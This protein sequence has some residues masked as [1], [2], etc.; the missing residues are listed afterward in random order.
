MKKLIFG[1]LALAATLAGP[2]IA[3]DMPV[4]ALPPVPVFSWTGCYAGLNVGPTSA[5]F[6]ESSVTSVGIPPVV[7]TNSTFADFDF[8]ARGASGGGQIGCNW[9]NGVVVWGVETDIQATQL[10][11]RKLFDN[12]IFEF[13]QAGA[14]DTDVRSA[15]RY[16]GTVRGRVGWTPTA[17][18]L[19]YL[20]GGFAYAQ[21]ASSLLF[22]T[23]AGV[24]TAFVAFDKQTHFGYTIGLGAEAKVAENF[25]VKLE[26]LYADVGRKTYNFLNV[27]GIN[28]RWDERV[29]FHTVRLGLNYNFNWYAPPVV[30]KY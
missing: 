2:A 21:V 6:R 8:P 30:A 13:P 20:T 10:E 14:F 1:S 27:A 4:K 29:D 16:F 23:A 19:L 28:Y 17:T 9:Q 5:R 15:I 25:T 22:P 18:T 7:P 12:S 24:T 26:Y 3:A 11:A